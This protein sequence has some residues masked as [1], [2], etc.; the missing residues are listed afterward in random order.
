MIYHITLPEAIHA[1]EDLDFISA[2]S[3][4]A[5]GFIHCSTAE[6]VEGVLERYFEGINAIVILSI[7]EKLL[8]YEL[9]YEAATANDF[10]PHI[11]G[12]INKGAIVATGTYHRVGNERFEIKMA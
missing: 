12:V 8:Q 4:D 5:E 10:F 6:Q 1:F 7:D 2:A 9:K 11:Y 3:L